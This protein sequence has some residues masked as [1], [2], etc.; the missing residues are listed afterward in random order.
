MR[1]VSRFPR[2]ADV[3]RVGVVLALTVL[4]CGQ[5]LGRQRNDGLDRT[6]VRDAVESLATVVDR[7][8]FDA[9]VAARVAQ[10]LREKLAQGS[11]SGVQTLKSLADML[12]RD[13]FE[14]TND[15]HLVVA[16]V[17]DRTSTPAST[18]SDEDREVRAR[19][20]NFGVQGVDV[21]AGNVGYLN[22]TSF[23]RPEEARETISAAM[24]ILRS[25]DALILDMRENS[26][27]SPDTVALLASYLFDAPGL[28]LFDIVPRSGGG[29][30]HYTTE[31]PSVPERNGIRPA[32][33]LTAD[34]T[35]S[36]GE[37]FA[38]LLQE[39]GRAEVVGE[40][41]AGA[42]NPGRPYAVN[43]QLE[44]TVPNGQVRTALTR[45]NWE[46]D[47]V[48]PNVTVPAAD[49]LR[50]AHIRALRELLKRVPSGSW[51]E[52]LKR[53]LDALEFS[54]RR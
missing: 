34:R 45:R 44:V 30:R 46:G 22:L 23:Y 33:V 11:Y 9:E 49:A 39:R 35:F 10:R 41:T 3:V 42:A 17:Q 6:V 54:D 37:G 26:G 12:S 53:Q 15:K 24:R 36:A 5:A 7:E 19:R 14:V 18:A 21:L 50:T 27:G 43:A 40:R 4:A 8:Y 2:A 38:F 13:L 28:P 29:G 52:T 47:G 25:A 1:L 16:I 51:Q 31:E 20:A 48:M 32:Y